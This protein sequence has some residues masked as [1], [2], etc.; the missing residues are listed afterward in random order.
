[1]R[2]NAVLPRLMALSLLIFLTGVDAFPAALGACPAPVRVD[3]AP[4][5]EYDALEF[6]P[7]E[8]RQDWDVSEFSDPSRHDPKKFRYI[9][10]MIQTSGR[11][12]I[13]SIYDFLA[14]QASQNPCATLSTSVIDESYTW[15]YTGIGFILEVPAE[16]IIAAANKD[17]VSPVL[18]NNK[19]PNFFHL[20]ARTYSKHYAPLQSPSQVLK[21]MTSPERTTKSKWNEILIASKFRRSF[22]IAAI[23]INEREFKQ[24]PVDPAEVR[25]L[26]E[27]AQQ[28]GLPVVHIDE[29]N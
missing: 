9:V 26:I 4:A 17:M 6:M 23:L 8:Q 28:E 5:P 20:Y 1:M 11:R 22:K 3:G 13:R 21:S 10:H 27:V 15:T 18:T 12:S 24:K 16:N 29:G 25:D 7:Q 14:T 2:K 19:E